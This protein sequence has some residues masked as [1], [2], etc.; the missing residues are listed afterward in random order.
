MFWS[1]GAE[2]RCRS[3]SKSI[4]R[5]WRALLRNNKVLNNKLAVTVAKLVTLK[6]D[7]ATHD[8]VSKRSVSH[9]PWRWV[10]TR[11][12][13]SP[14]ELTGSSGTIVALRWVKE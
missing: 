5:I 4:I 9:L 6:Q 3:F 14:H 8:L 1:V 7:R 10:Q 2:T 11:A 12:T 13:A